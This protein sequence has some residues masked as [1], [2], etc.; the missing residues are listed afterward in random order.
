MAHSAFV[1]KGRK[2]SRPVCLERYKNACLDCYKKTRVSTAIKTDACLDRYKKG[3]SSPKCENNLRG[4]IRPRI[5]VLTLNINSGGL[6]YIFNQVSRYLYQPPSEASGLRYLKNAFVT[7][8][9]VG[10]VST[11]PSVCLSV[12][13]LLTVL[14]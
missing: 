2:I 9:P 10:G 3:C 6:Y 8:N 11:A 7:R 5:Y 14:V 13:P 4:H 12:C 1:R